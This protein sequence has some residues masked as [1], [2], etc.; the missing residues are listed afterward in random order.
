M[1]RTVS[2]IAADRKVSYGAKAVECLEALDGLHTSDEAHRAE[3]VGAA[4]VFA[5]AQASAVLER[6]LRD[7]ARM[8]GHLR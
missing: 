3:Y 5:T 8:V 4:Q 1:P 2:Q 6:A 7:L